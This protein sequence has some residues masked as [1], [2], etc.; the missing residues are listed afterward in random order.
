MLLLVIRGIFI[1]GASILGGGVRAP[2]IRTKNLIS[3]V[4]AVSLVLIYGSLKLGLPTGSFSVKL[5]PSMVS[6]RRNVISIYHCSNALPSLL[7]GV[8]MAIVFSAKIQGVSVENMHSASN[9]YTGE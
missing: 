5:L 6:A 3:W 8:I 1:T 4:Y 7:L 2:R 9:F